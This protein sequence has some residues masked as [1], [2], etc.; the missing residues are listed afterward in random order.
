MI[1]GFKEQD[2][3]LISFWKGKT[4]ILMLCGVNNMFFV[5]SL[6]DSRACCMERAVRGRGGALDEVE[7]RTF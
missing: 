3:L 1:R 6:I 5:T 4:G 7:R 2:F